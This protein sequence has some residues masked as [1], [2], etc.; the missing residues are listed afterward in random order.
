[1][2]L[3]ILLR[4]RHVRTVRILKLDRFKKEYNNVVFSK[5]RREGGLL[6]ENNYKGYWVLMSEEVVNSE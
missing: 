4:R 1:M 3:K 5:T 2:I 6:V